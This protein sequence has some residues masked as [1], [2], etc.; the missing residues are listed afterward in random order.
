MKKLLSI[1]LLT[2]CALALTERPAQA[3]VNSKF[4]IGLNWN[5]QSANNSWLWGFWRNGQVPGPESFG[6]GPGAPPPGGA[7][8]PYLGAGQPNGVPQNGAAQGAFMPNNPGA[9]PQAAGNP[10]SFAAYNPGYNPGYIPG[11]NAAYNPGYQTVPPPLINAQQTSYYPNYAWQNNPYQAVSY[12]PGAYGYGYGSYPNYYYYP[13]YDYSAP[14]Y[15][16]GAR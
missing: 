14:Y 10:Y 11:Y 12:Q 15:W 5:M 6:P 3:W 1:A 4:S 13:V 7:P 9:Y 8:F 16:Y 2:V